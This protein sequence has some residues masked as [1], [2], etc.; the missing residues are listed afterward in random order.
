LNLS[1]WF[2]PMG[3]K[4]NVLIFFLFYLNFYK[5]LSKNFGEE[6]LIQFLSLFKYLSVAAIINKEIFCVHGGYEKKEIFC[7]FNS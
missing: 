6:I 4:M 5:V 7:K 2:N 1:K 3:S